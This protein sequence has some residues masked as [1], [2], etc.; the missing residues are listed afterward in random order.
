MIASIGAIIRDAHR[1]RSIQARGENAVG[2]D[3]AGS[4]GRA[5]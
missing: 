1:L 5:L 2:V 4:A 3:R